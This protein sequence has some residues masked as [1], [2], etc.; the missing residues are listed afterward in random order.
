MKLGK[1]KWIAIGVVT[2][3]VMVVI[4]G[5]GPGAAPPEEEVK[6]IKVGGAQP[7][8]GYMASDGRSMDEGLRMAIE[9]INE[10]GGVL[11]RPLEYITF[12]TKELLAETFAA[13]AEKLIVEEKVDVVIAGYSG[14][15]GP[16]TFGKYDVP[17]IYNEGSLACVELQQRNREEYWNVFHTVGHSY[18]MG[19][20]AFDM[21]E[22][23]TAEAGYEFPN[24]RICVIWAGWNW[25]EYYA[26]GFTERAVEK[27]WE[28]SM[29]VE[30]LTDV[31][32]WGGILAKIR[33]VDPAIIFFAVWDPAA[34]ATFREQFDRDPINALIVHNQCT[35]CPDYM[36]MMGEKADGELDQAYH[37]VLP[38]PRGEAW[39]ERFKE[40]TGR[41]WPELM[42]VVTYDELM[43]WAAAVE[44][45]GD[46][47]DY[48]AIAKAL[49]DY[50]YTGISGTYKFNEDH[51]VPISD[52]MPMF[53]YQYQGGK[54]VLLGL[55]GD[56][57]TLVEGTSF[58]VPPWI[59]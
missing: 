2:L 51:Y 5:C 16:D 22:L 21:L 24:N 8:T 52:D 57:L 39:F 28:I 56:K 35:I 40:F 13:A 4:A 42:S 43:M 15:A 58:Q 26:K 9:E 1:G 36:N 44:R 32:E 37:G 41:D 50:P 33:D 10:R 45:V 59:K 34:C 17:F 46:P 29:L 6:P 47:S 11:G 30:A 49:E 53:Y 20:L 27:G 7:M 38:G 23:V 31:R 12:D 48:R 55:M 54:K 25:D 14:E 19:P 18:A 3:L